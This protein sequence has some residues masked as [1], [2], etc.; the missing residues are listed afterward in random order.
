M[1]KIEQRYDRIPL[2]ET[3]FTP[4]GYLIVDIIITSVGIFEYRRPDGSIRRELRLPEE[5]F[6]P[7]SLASYKGKPVILTHEAG[8]I[9][10]DN[11][12]QEQIGTITT[13]LRWR[14]KSLIIRWRK[15][16]LF[17]IP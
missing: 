8:M 3:Y 12:Q 16:I 14:L 5:V 15:V 6:A 13:S 4:E 1:S 10:S 2:G 11:V 9:D 7:E 17:R